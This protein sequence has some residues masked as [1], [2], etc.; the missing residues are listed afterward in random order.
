[1]IRGLEKQFDLT[2]PHL[3]KADIFLI[4]INT[5]YGCFLGTVNMIGFLIYNLLISFE[6]VEYQ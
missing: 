3:T 1:M 5:K 6:F 4:K 2:S